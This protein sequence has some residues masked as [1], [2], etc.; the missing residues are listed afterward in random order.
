MGSKGGLWKGNR[1]KLIRG[2]GGRE[3]WRERGGGWGGASFRGNDG[4]D[5]GEAEAELFIVLLFACLFSVALALFCVIIAGTLYQS[6]SLRECYAMLHYTILCY[7]MLML[8]YAMLCYTLL[9]RVMLCH[10]ALS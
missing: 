1:S 8:C 7:A 2:E 3:R 10:A 4:N 9:C 5:P 6:P